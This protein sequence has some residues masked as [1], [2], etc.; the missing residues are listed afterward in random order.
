MLKRMGVAV[1]LSAALVVG[2]QQTVDKERMDAAAAWS[3]TVC[4]CAGQP[5]ADR[6]QCMEKHPQPPDPGSEQGMGSRPKYK[7]ESLKA[8]DGVKSVGMK[9]LMGQ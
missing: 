8:Y 2:C 1:A 3:K 9:C 7:L 4:E 6:A 5:G